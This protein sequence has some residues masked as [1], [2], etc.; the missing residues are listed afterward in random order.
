M[1][2][3][4]VSQ[5]VILGV[6]LLIVVGALVGLWLRPTKRFSI[7]LYLIFGLLGAAYYGWILTSG[8]DLTS[9]SQ[10]R[11]NLS[12]IL[13]LVQTSM[14]AYLMWLKNFATRNGH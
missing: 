10:S 13:R 12:A 9:L 14:I 6:H 11:T 4:I 8:E 7:V 3:R 5:W 2:V 1:T